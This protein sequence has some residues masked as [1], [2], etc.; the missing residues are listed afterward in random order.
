[1]VI[2]IAASIAAGVYFI[3]GPH[4]GPSSRTALQ[5]ADSG[6]RVVMGTFAHIIAV[7]SDEKTAETCIEAAFEQLK[8]AEK[9]MS[10]Y[11]ADS[12][13]SNINRNAYK[14]TVKVTGP[15]FELLSK[16]AQFS[17]VSGGAFDITIGPLMDMWRSAAE[18]NSLPSQETLR[19][20]L[21][22]VGYEKLILDR[23]QM[24]VRF[25]VEGMKLDLG[26][27]AKGYGVDMAVAAMKKNA[28]AGGLV[29]VGG[30]IRCFGTPPEGKKSWLIGLQEPKE[31]QGI[32]GSGQ[33]RLVL[34]LND[35]AVATSGDYQRFQKVGGRKYSHILDPKT[36]FSAGSLSSATVITETAVD[37]D[38]LGTAVSVMGAEQGLELIEK[39][40]KAEAILITQKPDY[41]LI[42]TSGADKYIKQ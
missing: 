10:I 8:A 1:M 4:T 19:Q 26:G 37:A 22:R 12:E 38:A 20:A 18:V 33:Y 7:A 39:T 23:K 16:S 13:I 35:A 2:I 11:K 14:E 15:T 32:P 42:K 30:N 40:P 17:K 41:K 3:K 25:A 28:A 29:D 31:A 36:G 9:T 21:L 34:T 24:T 27:I 5:S 6:Q